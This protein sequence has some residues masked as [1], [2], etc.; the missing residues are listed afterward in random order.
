MKHYID[1]G[2]WLE[3][4]EKGLRLKSIDINHNTTTNLPSNSITIKALCLTALEC[5]AKN[6]ESLQVQDLLNELG[7][8]R[9]TDD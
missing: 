1:L 2:F 5:I 6:Q 4:D 3:Q 8:S 7:I 9:Q